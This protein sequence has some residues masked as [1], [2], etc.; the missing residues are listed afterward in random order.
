MVML[1]AVVTF[2]V[3]SAIRI[4]ELN[5]TSFAAVFSI[6]RFLLMPTVSGLSPSMVTLSAPFNWMTPNPVGGAP[7]NAMSS[8]LG[9]IRTEVNEG[10]PGVLPFNVAGVPPSEVVEMISIVIAPW[11]VPELMAVK[12]APRVG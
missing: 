7:F 2:V 12:A 9:R 10:P 5:V 4:T 1:S 8:T 3:L 6:T 11:W